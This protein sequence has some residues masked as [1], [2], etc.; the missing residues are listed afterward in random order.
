MIPL[1]KIALKDVL[2]SLPCNMI[3]SLAILAAALAAD[4]LGVFYTPA[5]AVTGAAAAFWLVPTIWYGCWKRT[6]GVATAAAVIGAGAGIA[7]PGVASA[8]AAGL[9]W[10]F[11]AVAI[12]QTAALEV[13]AE[14][15][16][17]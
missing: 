7:Q 16:P 8:A 12:H 17:A 2:G 6:A 1:S 15:E 9:S 11:A 13:R 5:Q 14:H 4:R 3:A 10:I